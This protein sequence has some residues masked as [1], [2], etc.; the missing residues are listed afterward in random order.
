MNKFVQNSDIDIRDAFFEE[1]YKMGQRDK[2]VIFITDDLDSFVM[3]KYKKDLPKQFINIGVAEQNLM[4]V[5]AGLAVSGR[6]VFTYGICTYITMRCYE[7]I[8]YAIC[9]MKLPVVIIGVGAGF[10]FGYDGSTHHGTCDVGIMRL[11]PEISILNPSTA[12]SAAG[13]AKLAYKSKGPVYVRLDKGKFP[14]FYKNS[15]NFHDGY[16]IIKQARDVVIVS[17]GFMTQKAMAVASQF[18]NVGV[19]DVYRLK[20]INRLLFS[21]IL[22]KVKTVITLEENSLVGGLGSAISEII[23]DNDWGGHIKLKRLGVLDK[24]YISYGK[25]DWFHRLNSLDTNSIIKTIRT[26]AKSSRS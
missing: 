19:V 12:F 17:T 7:Q 11:I 10:S 6:K 16:S 8:R 13:C 23:L 4:D 21:N 14:E 1:I 2:N 9:S 22:S 3:R 18:N 20:P 25:R 24:Q 26:Y 15:V 5:A